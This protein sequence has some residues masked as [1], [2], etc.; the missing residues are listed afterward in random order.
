MDELGCSKGF[1]VY[2]GK[3][4]FPLAEKTK[5]IPVSEIAEIFR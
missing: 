2:P 3:E 1:V 5:V 4:E